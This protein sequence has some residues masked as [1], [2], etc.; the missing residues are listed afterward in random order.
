M[1]DVQVVV[2]AMEFNRGQ[3]VDLR[4]GHLRRPAALV[5][6][7]PVAGPVQ[8]VGHGAAARQH[9]LVRLQPQFESAGDQ[10]VARV[11]RNEARRVIGPVVAEGVGRVTTVVVL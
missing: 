3:A 1:I 8:P 4:G 6:I 2:P 11:R 9:A 10:Q 5:G 7:A